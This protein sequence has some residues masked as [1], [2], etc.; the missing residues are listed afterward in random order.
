MT[1]R[2][3]Q[4]DTPIVG[5]LVARKSSRFS[6]TR[7]STGKQRGNCVFWRAHWDVLASGLGLFWCA[8]KELCECARGR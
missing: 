2:P 6:R 1:G 5:D 8:H 7:L 3:E 4:G